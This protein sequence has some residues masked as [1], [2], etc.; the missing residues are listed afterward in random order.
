MLKKRERESILLAVSMGH[1][2]RKTE[3]SI[4]DAVININTCMNVKF[5]KYNHKKKRTEQKRKGS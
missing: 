2:R 3:N 4:F 1:L 5:L